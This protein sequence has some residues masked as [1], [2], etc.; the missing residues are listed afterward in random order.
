MVAERNPCGAG[1]E[2]LTL[3]IDLIMPLWVI[4]LLINN[5]NILTKVIHFGIVKCVRHTKER[6]IDAT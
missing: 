1:G 3:S 5:I 2:P 4:K 6:I